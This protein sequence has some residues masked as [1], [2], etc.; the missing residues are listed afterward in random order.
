MQA[1][2]QAQ[3]SKDVQKYFQQQGRIH[4]VVNASRDDVIL[5][6][7]LKGDP[8]LRLVLN[9][10]MPQPIH[11]F[12]DRIESQFSFSGVL[13]LC[14]IPLSA[15]WAAYPPELSME[16]GLMWESDIPDVILS[17]LQQME[18]EASSEEDERFER[19]EV[20]KE[21]SIPSKP[22]SRR[23]HLRVVK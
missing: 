18:S 21:T 10:R 2:S 20:S 6:D 3:K 4:I 1:F 22:S 9:C 5:P 11:F 17:T 16:D 15:I 19:A 12:H 23:S 7:F 14:V 8:A 13:S